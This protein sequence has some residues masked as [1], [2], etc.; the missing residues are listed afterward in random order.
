MFYEIP[1]Q[2]LYSNNIKLSYKNLIGN[3]TSESTAID[4][5]EKTLLHFLQQTHKLRYNIF[6]QKLKWHYGFETINQMEFD[7]F[8]NKNAT[9]LIHIN[10]NNVV[11]ACVRFISTDRPYLLG[12]CYPTFVENQP[13]PRTSEVSELTRFA[14]NTFDQL[15]KS[16][17]PAQQPPS[18]HGACPM[19]LKN[20]FP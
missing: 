16:Y 17:L 15:T 8:D 19:V 9:F 2:P 20:L 11:D 12:D 10:T 7:D 3:N 5:P 14:V 13:I 1:L 4:G 18:L 6:V